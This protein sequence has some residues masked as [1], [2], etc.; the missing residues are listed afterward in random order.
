MP[1]HSTSFLFSS[2]LES[3]GFHA[4]VVDGH[5]VE[6]LSKAFAEVCTIDLPSFQFE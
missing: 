1:C 5:D 6:E 4:I 2:R 3:F